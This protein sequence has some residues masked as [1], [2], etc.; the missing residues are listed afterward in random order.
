MPPT[1]VILNGTFDNGRSNWTGSDLETN[2]TENAYLG[3]GSSNRV[4]EM[5]GRSGRTTVMEQT[6]T[7]DDPHQ[8]QLSLDTALRTASNPQAGNEGFT[9]EVLD[10]NGVV[11]ASMTVL[12]TT[13]SFTTVTMQVDFPAA[14]DYTLRFTEVGLDDSLGAIV[15][16]ISLLVCFCHGTLIE[17]EFGERPIES[18]RAGDRVL[19]RSGLKPLRWVGQ[20][21]LSA[22]ELEMNPKLRPVRISEGAMGNGLP[23]RDLFVSRQ[24]RMQTSSAVA[25]RMFGTP[26][27]L[28]SAIKLTELP[29]IDID[30]NADQVVYFHLLFDAHEIVFANGAPSESLLLTDTALA[31]VTPQA[32]QEI[33]QAFPELPGQDNALPQHV[34]P[35]NRKQKRLID[36]LRKNHKPV[37]EAQP[38]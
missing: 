32:R 37:L 12:P 1:S 25:Q 33:R 30:R 17:T 9:V 38:S 29:G 3:N 11:I 24:H 7:L 19:T 10:S 27:V 22:V 35:K 5:D 8:G 20:R 34:I 16:N 18:L 28:I 21:H 31:S 36:R 15:D 14:G 13:N 23:R 26:E 4:A 6:F 2:H